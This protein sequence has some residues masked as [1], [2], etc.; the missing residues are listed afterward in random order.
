MKEVYNF[1]DFKHKLEYE[2]LFEDWF[3]DTIFTNNTNK[4]NKQQ[5]VH[6]LC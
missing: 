6:N 3:L 2:Q 4:V 5:F 1:H